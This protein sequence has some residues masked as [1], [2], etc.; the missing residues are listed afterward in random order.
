MNAP[1]F[2]QATWRKSSRSN[3]GGGSCIEVAAI[4][5]VTGVRDSKLGHTSPILPF[6]SAT[7]S[8][9]LTQVRAVPSTA[10]QPP[11]K[12]LR[13]RLTVGASFISGA[14]RIGI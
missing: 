8:S 3:G 13:P 10:D 5:R 4:P 2:T 1:D 7:W 11:G 9:F 6:T 14:E 12:Q